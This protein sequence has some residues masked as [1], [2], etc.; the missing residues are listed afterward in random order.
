[1]LLFKY[2]YYVT[3]LSSK[4]YTIWILFGFISA[5]TILLQ[6]L[7]LDSGITSTYELFPFLGTLA[8]VTIWSQYT[9][10]LIN[11]TGFFKVQYSIWIGRV[12]ILLIL[13]HPGLFLVQRFLDTRLF[14]PESYITYVGPLQAWAIVIAIAALASFLLYDILKPFR[15]KLIS[16][17]IWPFIS[18]LQA[19]AMIAIFIHSLTVGTSLST[20][21]F[22]VWWWILGIILVP[23]LV[24]QVIS[25]SRLSY[26]RKKD[27]G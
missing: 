21:Y 17:G 5:I 23:G 13:M 27:S 4:K 22:A 20:P 1:M 15:R 7:A 10:G 6:L 2:T 18:L 24:L 19:L 12:A 3:S 25:D 9:T 14:P 26:P 11:K 8:W 16:I